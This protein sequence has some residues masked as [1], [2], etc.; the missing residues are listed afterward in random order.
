MELGEFWFNIN[1]VTSRFALKMYQ[2]LPLFPLSSYSSSYFEAALYSHTFC[3]QT[4]FYFNFPKGMGQ[5]IRKPKDNWKNKWTKKNKSWI[6]TCLQP[7]DGLA[8]RL[9]TAR[10]WGGKCR[11]KSMFRSSKSIDPRSQ[12]PLC[13]CTVHWDDLEEKENIC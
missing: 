6:Q 10:K 1:L 8:A 2:V 11:G 5:G 4:I 12:T 9:L 13:Q 3:L 7:C